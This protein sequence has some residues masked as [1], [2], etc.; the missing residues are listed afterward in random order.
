MVKVNEKYTHYKRG[1]KYKIV[2]LAKHH[3]S[4]EPWVVY[5]SEGSGDTYIRS[6]REFEETVDH[7]GQRVARFSKL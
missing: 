3:E 6:L 4:F 7:G 5:K 2:A 1:G